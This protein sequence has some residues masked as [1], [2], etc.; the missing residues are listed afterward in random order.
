MKT[1]S[2]DLPQM[3]KCLLASETFDEMLG[4]SQKNARYVSERIEKTAANRLD[5]DGVNFGL[6][7]DLFLGSLNGS[8]LDSVSGYRFAP[9]NS[10]LLISDGYATGIIGE[11]ERIPVIGGVV[12][13]SI[14]R[15]K[16]AGITVFDKSSIDQ[17]GGRV[18]SFINSNLQNIVR[19]GSNKAFIEKILTHISQVAEVSAS[20]T[21]GA[22]EIVT[23]LKDSCEALD[24]RETRKL[25]LILDVQTCKNLALTTDST[26]NSV[27][28]NLSV[29]GGGDLNGIRVIPVGEDQLPAQDS[30]GKFCV[31]VDVDGVFVDRGELFLSRSEEA[32]I[33]MS[34]D[35]ENDTG[36]VVSLFHVDGVAL[37]A[38][39]TF[40]AKPFRKSIALI[41]G[42]DW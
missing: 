38:I 31:L 6:D 28:P 33:E 37:R 11:G 16:S 22:A 18:E 8:I 27:F 26:G 7:A 32:S 41:G 30:N 1:A 39:R 29:T 40:A 2:Q 13:D 14:S 4:Y 10:T 35:P 23:V 42:V 15:V 20:G 24:L 17:P 12:R 21:S 5:L 3:V 9:V 36:A 34:D 25:I 19:A